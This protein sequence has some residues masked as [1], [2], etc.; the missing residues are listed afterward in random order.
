MIYDVSGLNV[1]RCPKQHAEQCTSSSCTC[2]KMPIQHKRIKCVS[3]EFPELNVIS[4][5]TDAVNVFLQNH[6][7]HYVGVHCSYGFNRTGFI[8]CSYLA[9]YYGMNINDAVDTFAASRAPGIKHKWFVDELVRRYG[10]KESE[11]CLNVENVLPLYNIFES[12]SSSSIKE[13]TEE[14]CIN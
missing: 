3:K 10:K 13:R 9:E 7:N 14:I 11:T 1:P 5:F 12:C 2:E 6:P 8:V 4:A